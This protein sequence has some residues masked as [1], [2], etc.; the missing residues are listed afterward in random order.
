MRTIEFS[1][2]SLIRATERVDRVVSAVENVFPGLIMDIRSDKIEAY[3]G[4]DG[5]QTLHELFRR[6]RILDSARRVMRQGLSGETISFQLSKQAAFMGF[7]SFP[8][9]EEP[10]GSIHVQI[11]G[12]ES[13]I[14]WLAPQTRDGVPVNEINLLVEQA[15]WQEGEGQK[16]GGL[17]G[18]Q[19]NASGAQEGQMPPEEMGEELDDLEDDLED[20]P[21]DEAATADGQGR[22]HDSQKAKLGGA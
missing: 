1:V 15:R 12:G 18:E 19:Q 8:P 22:L 3:G 14:D 10:L 6:Q 11:K 9:E 20:E 2:C 21:M 13:V 17:S 7:V 16:P 5:L 4:P